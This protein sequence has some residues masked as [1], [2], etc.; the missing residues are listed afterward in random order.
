M[1]K[2]LLKFHAAVIKEVPIEKTPLTI[3]RKPDNDIVVDNPAV[4]SHH[5]RIV[6]QGASYMVED[7]QSTN[8]TFLN[9]KRI[10]NSA[11]HNNDTIVVGQH[12][13][14]FMHPEEQPAASAAP[15]AP[16]K[17]A[18]LDAT[19]VMIPTRQQQVLKQETG[20]GT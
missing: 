20:A 7:L 19:M 4:S 6:M 2:L 13:L 5:A 11:L 18:D 3:G 9:D 16:A 12:S 1:P 10:I 8:G 17:A 15:A 14:Q